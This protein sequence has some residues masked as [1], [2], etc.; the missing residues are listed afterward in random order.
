[1]NTKNTKTRTKKIHDKNLPR[2]DKLESSL[3][4]IELF[5]FLIFTILMINLFVTMSI[6]M[7]NVH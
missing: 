1:M 2:L 4:S 5:L 7:T 3:D 6:D